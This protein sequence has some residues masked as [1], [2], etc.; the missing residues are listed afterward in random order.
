[1]RWSSAYLLEVFEA[2]DGGVFELQEVVEFSIGTLGIDEVLKGIDDLFD[3]NN[4]TGAFVFTPEDHAIGA[5]SDLF[6]D[7]VLFVDL[8]VQLLRLFHSENIIF[9]TSFENTTLD[10][11]RE[12]EGGDKDSVQGVYSRKDCQDWVDDWLE[13]DMEV[14]MM[15]V[16][17]VG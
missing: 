16:I 7:L 1:M 8:V 5:L 14:G 10:S 17:L 9:T 11:V 6:F 13:L 12:D 4:A 2:Y 3:G 15:V